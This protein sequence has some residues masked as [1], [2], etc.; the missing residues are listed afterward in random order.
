MIDGCSFIDPYEGNV[1]KAIPDTY[2][3]Q[4]CDV[5]GKKRKCNYMELQ[6]VPNT[7][8]RYMDCCRSCLKEWRPYHAAA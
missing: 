5:C 6:G 2:T 1:W 4:I 3:P 8:V 7:A